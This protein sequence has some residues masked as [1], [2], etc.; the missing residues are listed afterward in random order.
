MAKLDPIARAKKLAELIER[1]VRNGAGRGLKSALQFFQARLIETMS[2]SANPIRR[3]DK[4]GN[5]RYIARTKA[6]KGAPIRKL[7]GIAIK[8]VNTKM[9][10]PL[11]GV[12]GI[13]ATSQNGIATTSGKNGFSYPRYH[14]LDLPGMPGS[15]QHKFIAPTVAK[16]RGNLETIIGGAVKVGIEG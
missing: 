10:S 9:I 1:D 15:G 13:P 12:I 4:N 11:E 3:P 8:S 5:L 2:V 6:T 16:H 14:E 7:S